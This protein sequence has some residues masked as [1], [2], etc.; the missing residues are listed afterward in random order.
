M[1]LKEHGGGLAHVQRRVHDAAPQHRQRRLVE[2][3]VRAA[4]QCMRKPMRI[5]GWQRMMS[6]E[7]QHDST[8]I[9]WCCD[10]I[11]DN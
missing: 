5:T 3:R 1:Y 10:D 6:G 7:L 11:A 8:V 2:A 9:A 4:T